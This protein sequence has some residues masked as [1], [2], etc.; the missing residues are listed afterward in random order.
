M[1][2]KEGLKKAVQ[3]MQTGK[4]FPALMLVQ[5]DP[6]FAAMVSK[7]VKSHDPGEFNVNKENSYYNL[8]QS[9]IQTISDSIKG[10]IVDNENI[11]QLFPDIELAIQIIVSSILSPKDMVNTEIII[12]GKESVFPSEI[13]LKLNTI[14]TSNLDGSYKLKNELQD[15][16][17]D[18]LFRTGS[19]V[20]AIIP[21]SIVDELI[22]SNKTVSTEALT[23]I[24]GK[25]DKI[26]SLGFLGNASRAATQTVSLESRIG[27]RMSHEVY[28]AKVFATEESVNRYMN[29][30][31]TDNYQILKIP[32]LMESSRKK[33]VQSMI[34]SRRKI[35]LEN[36]T[37]TNQEFASLVY[38]NPNQNSR[39]FVAL[40]TPQASKRK[41]IGRPLVMKLPSEAV[42]PVYV[43]GN[44]KEH[45]G[46]FVLLDIDGNPVTL[47]SDRQNADGLSSMLN[48][49]QS[50]N[51]SLS[52]LLI[53]KAKRNL[54]DINAS[55]TID[56]ISKIYSNI[57]ETDLINRLNNGLYKNNFEISKNEEIYRIMLARSLA[58]KFTRL[59]YL[60]AELTTY[61]AFKYFSNGIGKSYLDDIKILT[62]L[63][64]ILLFAKIMAMTKNS[65][66]T[67][68]VDISLD[69]EDP[70]PQKSIEIATHEIVKLRQQYFPLGVNS[71]P[72][73]VNWIQRA[74]L[75]LNIKNHPGLPQTE[76]DFQNSNIEHKIPDNEFDEALRKQTYMS[77]G[78]SPEIVDQ[79]F[80]AEFATTAIQNNILF[81][82][83]VIQAQQ[84]FTLDL[85]DYVQKISM[86][87]EVMR[88]EFREVIK[89]NM[90]S[91]ENFLSEEDKQ[92]KNDD[93]EGFIEDLVDRYI[94]NIEID[95][96]KPDVTSIETQS[97]AFESYV[98][99]L[100]K[101]LDSWISAEIFPNEIAGE[102]SSNADSMKVIL[103]AHFIRDWMA[104]NGFMT[105]LNDIVTSDEDG[106]PSLDIYEIT[107]SH[108][109]G[110]MR[111]SLNFIKN[112]KPVS[113]AANTDLTNMSVDEGSSTGSDDTGSEDTGDAGGDDF[114][115]MSS[116][117]GDETAEENPEEAPAEDA[118]TEEEPP[119]E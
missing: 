7:L 24:V 45:I 16:L 47:S 32:R 90:A 33:T 34:R 102:I 103:R 54:T 40:P 61:F 59:L 38:K 44:E 72:D 113:T 114:G 64:A 91:I 31:V 43:P 108:M 17:R 63:R 84:L 89:E 48:N 2:S 111:T 58:G 65:I 1:N 3:S 115:D 51:Q 37:V 21:E 57:V 68:K 42:I 110:L 26:V 88:D 82:K 9:Q 118:A 92:V 94:E 53:S 86:N 39:V 76:F 4:K 85:T 60:P 104:K 30:D 95:L 10:R 5:N 46:Y 19:Y 109:E 117:G 106:K 99:A 77:M 112:M 83:R 41:S 8:N 20:K 107:K 87:D 11:M 75:H 6:Q 55:P 81:S 49:D 100:D 56:Q 14:L 18:T 12:K 52:S 66:S 80:N 69:P 71:P 15:I 25:D 23:D 96:P 116:F 67:T 62:S 36:K 78:L 70:D 29:L 50:N 28:D 13:L 35:S 79:G 98:E 27:M 22:N 74:G 119:A 101:T 105:E 93:P 97:T 73:L